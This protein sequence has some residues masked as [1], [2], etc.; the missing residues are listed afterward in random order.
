MDRRD[1]RRGD[2]RGE[3]RRRGERDPR[4]IMRS[5]SPTPAGIDR[6]PLSLRGERDTR[7]GERD[8]RFGERE[9]RREL[10][11]G[12]RLGDDR[13]REV[14]TVNSRVDSMSGVGFGFWVL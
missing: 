5:I 11:R 7:R 9:T 10:R 12:E 14:V 4:L 1:E 8:A 13:R 3:E 2:R 6:I